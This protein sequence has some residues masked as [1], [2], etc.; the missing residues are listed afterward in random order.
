MSSSSRDAGPHPP[1]ICRGEDPR[2]AGTYPADGVQFSLKMVIRPITGH[3]A[4]FAACVLLFCG[5]AARART[6]SAPWS[7]NLQLASSVPLESAAAADPALLDRVLFVPLRNGRLVSVA[8]DTGAIRWTIDL[9]TEPGLTAGEGLV[10]VATA[11]ALVAIGADGSRRWSI[12]IPGGFSA[13]PI[14]NSGWLIA[15]TKN[16]E[17][18]GIRAQDGEVL[19]TARL[20][21]A[22]AA[23]PAFGVDRVFLPIED[24]QLVA[25]DV[26]SGQVLWQ[27]R[28][29]G[30][31]G[32]PLAAADRIFVGA[33]DRWFY[34]LSAENGDRKWRWRHGGLITAAP[35]IDARHVYVTGLNNILRALD[36]HGGSQRW[37]QGL[38]LRPIGGPLVMDELVVVA[39]IGG[40]IR[41]YRGWTGEPAGEFA[42]AGDLAVAPLLV[43]HAV[44]ELTGLALLIR[45]GELQFARRPLGVEVTPLKEAFGV[46]VPLGAPPSPP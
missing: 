37:M 11:D 28:L 39:G 23:R 42:A 6:A 25:V 1:V 14:W 46:Q 5:C 32:A 31:P 40:E 18:L 21:G 17:V 13:P 16:G 7:G 44:P 38:P 3:A 22:V 12:P 33:A 41:T 19:W 29:G 45:S 2:L 9:P 15:S 35:A 20:P 30:R 43:P 24:G 26:R 36:R 10:F 4:V 34:C 8:I 27:R